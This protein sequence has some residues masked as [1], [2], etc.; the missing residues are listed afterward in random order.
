MKLLVIGCGSIGERHISNLK[1]LKAGEII[2]FDTD[3]KRLDE[4]AS[5]HG[6]TGCA[7][8]ESGLAQRPDAALVCTPPSSHVGIA[9]MSVKAGCHVFIEKPL[10]DRLDGIAE[11]AK[12][13]EKRRLAILVG[14]C[15]RFSGL[16]IAKQMIEKGEIGRPLY[17]NAEFAQYLPDWRPWQDYRKSYTAS[18]S[19]GGG[20]ILDGSHEIDYVR[21]VMGEPEEVFCYAGRMGDLEVE[22]E[23]TADMLLKMEGNRLARIHVDFVRKGYTRRME[24]VGTEGTM[25]WDFSKGKIMVT[26]ADGKSRE[27][28]SDA[29]RNEMYVREM[30][31]FISCI[32]GK[33]KPLISCADA[34]GTLKVALAAKASSSSKGPVNP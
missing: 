9:L 32:R 6:I 20:I 27:I 26:G 8:I 2:A 3:G 12:E 30:K 33:E 21:W 22:T 16:S 15:F 4:V 25:A 14:Y 5:K 11:L 10:S 17:M 13:A 24:V 18:K 28:K 34:M 31:H 7:S 23:D 1:S 29:D 19:M